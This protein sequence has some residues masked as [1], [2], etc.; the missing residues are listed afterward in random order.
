MGV[1]PLSGCSKVGNGDGG[2]VV[3]VAVLLTVSICG[4]GRDP[5]EREPVVTAGEPYSKPHKVGNRI[6]AK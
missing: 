5:V 1:A 4:L 3:M 2:G 6:K